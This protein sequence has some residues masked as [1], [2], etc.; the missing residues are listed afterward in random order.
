MRSMSIAALGLALLAAASAGCSKSRSQSACAM[1]IEGV[2]DRS[3]STE[4]GE[5]PSAVKDMTQKM[6]VAL[7]KLCVEEK[8]APTILECLDD[9]KDPESAKACASKLTP[10][11]LKKLNKSLGDLMGVPLG[12]GDKQSTTP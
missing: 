5:V 12:D 2:L 7:T 3:L 8:W 9:A 11:Q 10:S 4:G 6:G 1:A